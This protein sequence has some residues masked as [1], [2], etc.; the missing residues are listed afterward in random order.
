[1]GNEL[2]FWGV[3][4]EKERVKG[5]KPPKVLKTIFPLHISRGDD[6]FPNDQ[7]SKHSSHTSVYELEKTG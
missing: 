4:S 2:I 3:G 7:R 1:V 6:L 5:R